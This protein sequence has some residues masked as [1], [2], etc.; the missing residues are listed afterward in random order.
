MD[1][2]TNFVD[3]FVE[4][5]EQRNSVQLTDILQ[6]SK[7]YFQNIAKDDSELALSQLFDP[8]KGLLYYINIELRRPKPQKNFDSSIKEAF[9]LLGFIMEQ[10]TDI[11]EP[12]II[13]SKNTCQLALATQSSGYIQK[14]AC[15][16]FNTLIKLFKDFDMELNE[17][18][19]KFISIF[20]C[21]DIKERALLFSVLGTISKYSPHNIEGNQ[22]TKIFVQ[23][24]NDFRA[25]Y[26][27]TN[28]S[29]LI[30]VFALYFEVLSDILENV[31]S[32]VTKEHYTELYEWLKVFCRPEIY[33]YKKMSMKSAANLLSTHMQLFREFVY[34]D[35]EYWYDLLKR[36]SEYKNVEYSKYGQHALRVFYRMIGSTLKNKTS[37]DDK[38]IFLYFKQLFEEQIRSNHVNSNPQCFILYGYSQIAAPCKR[39]LSD[40]DVENMFSLITNCAMPLFSS[41]DVGKAYLE[42]IC[43]Y[44]EALSEIILHMSALTIDQINVIT[45]LSVLLIKRFP[46]FPITSRD[47]AVTSFINTIIHVGSISKDLLEEFLY[48]TIHVGIIW[49]CS[50]TLLVD[51][52]LQRAMNHMKRPICYKDYL[53]L[54][55]EL[56]N[57]NRYGR[58][59]NIAQDVIDMTMHVAIALMEKL[60]LD[61]KTKEDSVFSDA[62]YSQVAE[63]VA[64]FRIFVNMVDLYFDIIQKLEPLLLKN[65]VNKFL[66][67]VII[68]SYRHHLVSGF[69]KLVRAMYKHISNLNKDDI[70]T[71]TLEMLH[72]YLMNALD[73]IPTFSNELLTTSLLLIL[74][75]PTMYVE[76]IL[77][78]T[79]P[80][81]KIAFTVG[82]SDFELACVALD[83]LEKWKNAL[84]NQRTIT[85]LQ[86]ILPFLEPYLHSEESSTE[87][88]QDIIKAERKVIKK[89]VSKDD[90]T[91]QKFQG[92][93]LL[94][95]ASLDSDITMNYIYKRSMDTGVTWD[96]KDLLEYS[97]KLGDTEVDIYFDK[98]LPRVLLLAQSSSDRRTKIIACEVL[99]SILA[100]V[101]GKTARHLVSNP[102]RYV[103]IYVMLCPA[104]LKL[105]CDYDETAR[106]MFQPL[107]LQLTHWLSS[108]F[109]LH[110]PATTHFV[111]SLFQGLCNDSNTSLREFCGLCLAE[112]T[113]WSIKQSNNGKNIEE[114]VRKMTNF[115]LHPSASKRIAAATAFNHLYTILR[116]DEKIVSTYWLEILYNFVKS[117]DGCNDPSI[118]VALGHVEKVLIV[119]KNLLN[120]THG[121]RRKPVEFEDSTLLDA[122]NWLLTQCGC[123]DQCRR[124]K[125]VELVVKLSEHVA[126]FGSLKA[127]ITNYIETRGIDAFNNI[128]SNGL[129]RKK[130]NLSHK[131]LLPLLRSL[132]CYIWLIKDELLDVQ[133]LF[134]NS[135]QKELIFNC[136]S[137]FICVANRIKIEQKD[138]D[139]MMFT[140]ELEDLQTLQ[141]KTILALFQ[142]IQTLIN[143]GFQDNYFPDVFFSKDLNELIAK[144]IMCPHIIGFDSKN[145]EVAEATPAIVGN[146]LQSVAQKSASSVL[147]RIK[148]ELSVYV[149]KHLTD[150]I[151]LDKI[152][153]KSNCSSGLNHYVQGLIFLERHGILDQLDNIKGLILQS[154]DLVRRMFKILTTEWAKEL[155]GTNIKPPVKDYLKLIMEF[156]L[157]RYQPSMT[158]TLINLVKDNTILVTDYGNIGHGVHFLDTFKNEI[159]RYMLKDI[160][161]TM[162]TLNDMS[163][164]DP[165]LFLTIM[166]KL[167]MFVQRHKKQLPDTELLT[168]TVIKNFTL[169]ENAVSNFSYRK[170]KLIRIFGIAIHLKKEPTETSLNEDLY[171]WI[172]RELIENSDLEYKIDILQN[173]LMCLASKE[174]KEFVVILRG[175][176]NDRLDVCP[177]DFSDKNA[178]GLKVINCFQKL[179][180]LVPITKSSAVFESVISFAAGIAE[181]VCTEKTDECIKKYFASI[182]IDHAVKSMNIAYKLFIKSNTPVKERFEVLHRFLLPLFEFCKDA[183][184]HRFFEKNIKEIHTIILQSVLGNTSDTTQLL[185]S[186]IGC[187]DLIGIMF[188]K[189]HINDIDNVESIITQNAMGEV[190]TGRELL[191]S[192]YSNALNVRALKTPVH[193]LKE[194]MR[195]LHCSAY[196]CSIAILSSFK[197]DEDSYVIIF[198]ENSKKEQ[199][200]WENI[201]DCQKTYNFE[202]TMKEYPKYRKRLIN[203]RKSIRD[204]QISDH[205]SYIYS[206]DLSTSTLTEDM[207]AYDFNEAVIHSKPIRTNKEECMSLTFEEDELNNH[208]CMASICGVLSHMISK[209][210]STI[211]TDE[212]V[213]MPK[214]LN[215]FQNSILLAKY[216][217]IRLFML[218]IILNMQTVFQPYGKFLFKPI[219][220]AMCHYLKKNQLNYII[221]DVLEMLMDWHS[222]FTPT[223]IKFVF[224]EDG[225]LFQL[226]WEKII[227]KTMVGKTAEIS[228]AI[229]EYNMNLVKTILEL[230]HPYLKL[231]QILNDKMTNV[232]EAAVFLILICLVNNMKD[233]ILN[234][235]DIL[236]FLEK[237]LEKWK[238]NEATVLQCCECFGLILKHAGN[239]T[240]LTERKD[241]IIDKIRNIL[242]QMQKNLSNRL[243]NCI[244]ALC[245]NY[246]PAAMTYFVFVDASMPKVDFQGKSNCLEIFL[247][248]VPNF[249]VDRLLKELVYTQFQDLLKKRTSPC[250]KVSLKIINSLVSILPAA[251]ILSLSALAVSYAKHKLSEY[252]DIAYDIFISIYKKYVTDDTGANEVKE[253][254][255]TSRE[256]L[257]NA[258]LDPTESLQ[259]KVCNFWTQDAQLTNTCKK[260]L[261]ETLNM[262]TSKVGNNFLPFVLLLIFDLTKVSRDYTKKM[263]EPLQDCN[264]VDY[265]IEGCWRTKNLGS[266]AP[267]F[268]PSLT[269][270]T[271]Q[272]FTQTSATSSNTYSTSMYNLSSELFIRATQE[273]EFEPTYADES[274]MMEIDSEEENTFKMPRV[275]EPAYNKKSKRFL[276]S[277]TNISA[278][279]RQN[280]IQMN[281]QHATMIKEEATRQRNT[282][283]LYRKYRIGDFPDIEI[284]HADLLQTLQQL[285]KNDQTICKDIIV[286][287]V[288]SLIESSGR[289]DFTEKLG[290]SVRR[291]IEDEQGN[292]SAMSA[293]FEIL[294]NP[295][296]TNC[297]LEAIGKVSKSNGLNFHGSLILEESIIYEPDAPACSRKKMRNEASTDSSSAWLQLTNL[298]K[299]MNDVDMVLSIFQNHMKN[300]DMQTASFAQVSNNWKEAKVAYEK[301]YETNSQFEKEHCLQGLFDS[302]SNMCKWDQID[303]RIKS[304]LNENSD[305]IWNHPWKDWMF[306]WLIDAHARK[307]VNEDISDEFRDDVEKVMEAWLVEEEKATYLKR[308]FGN[309]LSLFLLHNSLEVAREFLLN[310][311]DESREQW[312]R[313]HPLSTQLRISNLQ[314]VR[315]TNDLNK[316]VKV[317]KSQSGSSCDDILRYWNNTMPSPQDAL[318]PWEKLTSYRLH[319]IDTFLSNAQENN[320]ESM[321]TEMNE[322]NEIP[323]RMRATAFTMRLKIIETAFNQRNKYIAEKYAKQLESTIKEYAVD[324]H[325]EFEMM[326]TKIKYLTGNV[327]TDTEK[328]LSRYASAWSR[329]H[330]LLQKEE[331]DETTTINARQQIS[332]LASK[333]AQLCEENATFASLLIENNV[334]LDKLNNETN[335]LSEIRRA[336]E[337]YSLEHLKA[338]CDLET[339]NIKECYLTLS[340]YCYDRLSR[341]GANDV[342]LSKQ[343]VESILK[344]MRHGSLEAAHYFPC[345]LKPEYLSDQ[346][347]KDIFVKESEAVQTWLFLSWQAQLF[348]HLGTSIAPLII[349]ILKRIVETY[350]NAVIYTFRLTV[351][352]NPALMNETSTYDIRQILYNKPEIERF[353]T[354]LK[355]SIPRNIKE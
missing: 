95:I 135:N 335:D 249:T 56:L 15:G 279:M 294:L 146:M 261:L 97:L 332:E 32:E 40:E 183:V 333:I 314:K 234:R 315:I 236:E 144:C 293:V 51:A 107:M 98:I 311:L 340:K 219:V 336:L 283:K 81:F 57:V 229:Y 276:S 85:F 328:K 266:K 210:I 64:D 142:F 19:E 211:P 321:E 298:Y 341:T 295:R 238:K 42:S 354:A 6:N 178:K 163:R 221:V 179:V 79:I 61:T 290:D 22:Y 160:E 203:I 223:S 27:P 66:S 296:I 116:E 287:I 74:E 65:T 188:A 192:L 284:S 226:L 145:V 190:S 94:F 338:C 319:I 305:N 88:L 112:F 269:S 52:E 176:R 31:S 71:E 92:R 264:Y 208:E 159:F 285:A 275:P 253:L 242:K 299:S 37:Q 77:D 224:D 222:K 154:E 233:E 194:M 256:I 202:Q 197:R 132:D 96:K 181:H 316:S 195:L 278:A 119:K 272:M 99:H 2:F 280:Q 306:T 343:F 38:T 129:Q 243:V 137:N 17:T 161:K 200:I 23:L 104:L 327:E 70:E 26:D 172:L 69:Y 153:H 134:G 39:Y 138:R 139:F 166:E 120:A 303:K 268:V 84:D 334:I 58:H 201:I 148:S 281:V 103:P 91:L 174:T 239:D 106:K 115:T 307:L 274:S 33:S 10:F 169:F 312:I 168:D 351:E 282:V 114:V 185:V 187:Y 228:K 324:K 4:A 128:I 123:L 16:V 352:T 124:A 355:R 263:F 86:E 151:D 50:H 317:L 196:N 164:E 329:C 43:N 304:R 53:P 54:W 258:M 259:N 262:Y 89:I 331:L 125:C 342:Q 250:E 167:F 75:V 177:K 147:Y 49:T 90:N 204:R 240:G 93:V 291:I 257:I 28:V 330:S 121:S 5:V 12:Y 102:N 11:F 184:I 170:D 55:L 265:K 14:A 246:P 60:N 230:W 87:F 326:C 292:N 308:V 105:G 271:N 244:Y 143:S 255:C 47:L 247:L 273:L 126:N 310:T 286:S 345:L 24:I 267:L 337:M 118:I 45:K 110:S 141:C 131:G 1:S 346:E 245:K 186:K 3:L 122:V 235:P 8:K 72:K 180:T 78:D 7:K 214:W 48:N 157:M 108:K 13:N 83:A 302:L 140:K 158:K 199:L 248:C 20:Y 207:N 117:L 171:E 109:M 25:Q 68:T 111:D 152:V 313:L 34:R 156:L 217:N 67:K 322:E 339:T 301:A 344:A 46:D 231:P 136:A 175:L 41:D 59:G 209:E 162:E 254:M 218:K 297:S 127:I 182:T 63:N 36:L 349:P 165:A 149:N 225:A 130:E 252:R 251:N 353:L 241:A 100:F 215:C 270:Q 288:Y 205:Y 30:D 347:T 300:E 73:L 318:I 191:Q 227:E 193:E 44:Q 101:L 29:S 80:V 213:T 216:D 348:S 309:E 212:H 325:H 220:N 35:Y 320:A 277:S 206:Y 237:Q 82:I 150:F 350:P 323:N 133:S 76:R 260:R 21:V 113:K 18:V 189:V 9:H 155:I 232:P 289:D 62:A 173:F 198:A